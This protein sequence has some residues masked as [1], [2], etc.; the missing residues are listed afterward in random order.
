[1][2]AVAPQKSYYLFSF[3]ISTFKVETLF[4]IEFQTNQ[5]FDEASESTVNICQNFGCFFLIF[6]IFCPS[7]QYERNIV[8]LKQWRKSYIR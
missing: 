8:R 5:T 1:M 6:S 2:F 3:I 7:R 4:D